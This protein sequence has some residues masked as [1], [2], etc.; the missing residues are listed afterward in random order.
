MFDKL[1]VN[2][3]FVIGGNRK[4]PDASET[5]PMLNKVFAFPTTIFIDRSGTVRRIHTGFSGPGTGVYYEELVE[6]FN[7]FMDLLLEEPA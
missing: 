3:D 6:E 1:K 5:L 4:Q 2:Y 7:R